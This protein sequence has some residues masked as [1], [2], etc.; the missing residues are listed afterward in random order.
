MP[1]GS[2]G[3]LFVE[4]GADT[5]GLDKGI[6]SAGAAIDGLEKK[7]GG[8]AAFGKNMTSVGSGM[9]K[10]VTV[11]ILAAGVA[12]AAVSSKAA[13]FENSMNEV[14][15][16]LP[17]LSAD[18]MDQMSADALQFSTDF[19]VLSSETVPAL[20]QAI[21]AGV[22]KD[23]VFNFLEVA[24]K[25]AIG[26]V[27]DLETA[28]DGITSVVNA[29]GSDVIGASEASDLMFTAV[30]KGKTTMDELSKSLFN[31][32]PTASALGVEF[33]DIT[34]ALASMT[35]QGT[36]TSVATTQLRQLLVELS[37]DG[38]KTSKA[39]KEIAGVGFAEFIAQG[40]NV[41]GAM[42][43]MEQAADKNNVALS[44]MF[45]SVEA[46][47][48]ALKITGKGA[49]GFANNIAAMADS[50]GATD[51]AFKK[52]DEGATRSMEQIKAAFDSA[53]IK[54]GNE[55][56]PIVKDDLLPIFKDVLVPLLTDV[57]V[58][59]IKLFAN[60]FS[61]LPGPMKLVAIGIVG[62]AAVLGPLL[63][64]AGSLVTAGTALSVALGLSGTAAGASSVGF[65]AA[66]AGL[67]AALAPLLP[68]IAAAALLIGALYLLWKNFG[69][70][71]DAVLGAS[72]SFLVLLGP[73]GLVL[74][75]IR[76]W[77]TIGPFLSNLFTTVVNTIATKLTDA[78]N[79]VKNTMDRVLSFLS[80]LNS[81]FYQSGYALLTAFAN[82]IKAAIG[83]A[84]AAV[85]SAASKLRSYLP[86]SDADKGPLSDITASGAALMDT[87]AEGMESG[88]DLGASFG[89]LAPAIAPQAT[90]G[91]ASGGNGGM[92]INI[93]KVELTEKYDFDALM[94][95]INAYQRGQAQQRGV[96]F[97]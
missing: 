70:I 64:V 95:D 71:K 39:F 30:A 68:F 91:A 9:T 6:A 2:L 88:T 93:N 77:D 41:Q 12:F 66:A 96:S 48:A 37:K 16:L 72:D 3:K 65:F 67:W 25:A 85:K 97:V 42:A 54:I 32:I 13:T 49:E 40:G 28:V 55:F 23:N 62:L 17:N 38:G 58:P 47:N 76:H 59:A 7:G 78:Y 10:G 45:G 46:G 43:I 14:F 94:K 35:A 22:P 34:A 11:P 15:T 60:A 86:H 87:F 89:G 18:A 56:L 4:I 73:I 74:L 80:G 63:I 8:M 26:G 44:D 21:S 84:L 92:T 57:V 31:V 82:G 27:T 1:V 69:I 5:D 53:M 36:P 61:I 50:A 52:M 81:S 75:A 19:G 29:Y 90:G 24:N 79:A 33:G 20:Y 51:T 83:N